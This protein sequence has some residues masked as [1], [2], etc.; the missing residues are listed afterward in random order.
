[1]G[2]AAPRGSRTLDWILL[3][4]RDN[5][6]QEWCYMQ[7]TRWLGLCAVSIGAG[8]VLGEP[9][10]GWE[11]FVALTGGNSD[12]R[13]MGGVVALVGVF[14][15]IIGDLEQDELPPQKGSP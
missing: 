5:E 8:V 7:L 10:L 14:T 2:S 9:I 12:L 13:V 15:L 1:L 3:W 11:G 6:K 4:Y